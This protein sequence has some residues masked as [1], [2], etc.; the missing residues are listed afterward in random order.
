[1]LSRIVAASA[2]SSVSVI[3]TARLESSLPVE[4]S[5]CV[6]LIGKS[7]N[8]RLIFRIET[9][10]LLDDLSSGHEPILTHTAATFNLASGF[11]PTIPSKSLFRRDAETNTRDACATR[12]NRRWLWRRRVWSLSC[13]YRRCAPC[14]RR[15]RGQWPFQGAWPFPFP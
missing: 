10:D 12:R 3:R 15:S 14:L 13:P 11:L 2:G 4:F 1:M 9:F 6:E 8:A 5:L 7:N